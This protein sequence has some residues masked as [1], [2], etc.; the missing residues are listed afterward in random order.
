MCYIPINLHAIFQGNRTIRLGE[1]REHTETYTDRHTWILLIYIYIYIYTSREYPFY[2]YKNLE[3]KYK[4]SIFLINFAKHIFLKKIIV[5]L[6]QQQ[7]WQKLSIP[8]LK[9]ALKMI[10][11][12]WNPY[13]LNNPL[14][15]VAENKNCPKISKLSTYVQISDRKKSKFKNQ[16]PL[17]HPPYP[18]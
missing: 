1:K 7:F 13:L 4:I 11:E 2:G 15:T 5:T 16:A 14:K 8:M 3:L 18:N 10:E 17:W 12:V 9:T 6:F